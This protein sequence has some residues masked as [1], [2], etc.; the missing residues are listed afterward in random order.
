MNPMAK[1]QKKRLIVCIDG[2]FN[3]PMRLTKSASASYEKR[4]WTNV[5]KIRFLIAEQ[6]NGGRTPVQQVTAYFRGVGTGVR[7][8]ERQLD[9]VKGTGVDYQILDAYLFLSDNFVPGDEIYLIGYSRGAAAAR[10]L[11]GFIESCGLLRGDK[12][13]FRSLKVV[14]QHFLARFDRNAPQS[15]D[16]TYWKKW[17]D[18]VH[19]GVEIKAL[20]LWDTVFGELEL[21]ANSF[22]WQFIAKTMS[23]GVARFA[24]RD[25]PSNVRHAFHAMAVDEYRALFKLVPF[26]GIRSNATTS[27]PLVE[28]VWFPGSHGNVGGGCRDDGLSDVSLSWMI[29]KLESIDLMFHK[30]NSYRDSVVPK[31]TGKIFDSLSAK[32]TGLPPN[33]TGA[34]FVRPINFHNDRH[35]LP[36]EMIHASVLALWG[37]NVRLSDE[38]LTRRKAKSRYPLPVGQSERRLFPPATV[39][40]KKSV[41]EAD[42]FNK[43]CRELPDASRP[44]TLK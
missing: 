9:G 7:F 5:A 17:G 36:G 24:D 23:S 42:S 22:P 11:A 37:T 35:R 1:Q 25:L 39:L 38:T 19:R 34:K 41:A 33:G 4:N 10:A 20:A 14:W 21:E 26:V 28:Q 29:K 32:Y 30:G 15:P 13:N 3:E 16:S 6:D 18:L 43:F 31:L 44:F 27:T 12:A 40:A 2:T 8:Y